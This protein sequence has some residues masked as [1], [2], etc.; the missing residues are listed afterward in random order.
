MLL[1]FLAL[2]PLFCAYASAVSGDSVTF[3]YTSNRQ[4]E[5]EPCDCRTNQIG[6]LN[7]MAEYLRRERKKG[8]S[9]FFD[10]GDSFFSSLPINPL[11]E[12]KEQMRSQLI[13]S[14]YKKM[15]LTAFSPGEKDFALGVPHLNT[16][17]EK[18]GATAVSANLLDMQGLSLF[19][20]YRILEVGKK[21]IGVTG[22][23]DPALVGTLP[24]KVIDWGKALTETISTLRKKGVKTVVVLSHLGL[25]YDRKLAQ[26]FSGVLIF[27]SHSLDPLSQPEN[28]NNSFIFQPLHQGQQLGRL[29]W[30]LA[31]STKVSHRLV[32]LGKNYDVDND[33]RKMMIAFREEARQLALTGESMVAQSHHG[34][35]AN[36]GLCKSCHQ[37][38]YDFWKGTEHASSYL[39]LYAK[40]QHLDSEC[41]GCHALGFQNPAGFKD[42]KD[43]FLIAGD[44]GS[45]FI[46]VFM[47]HI[48]KQDKGSGTL[49]A[50]EQPKR[51]KNLKA[52]YHRELERL[53]LTGTINKIYAGVQ[54]ENCHGNR[55]GHPGIPSSHANLTTKVSVKTCTECHTTER[56]PGFKESMIKQ[57]ACPL[58]KRES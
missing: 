53:E 54:C 21:K 13:A 52:V 8:H 56:S 14:A 25:E 2:F 16:L 4:G 58:M 30:N 10:A 39:P 49:S 43:A 29:D 35:V 34:F 27:G 6:G 38:Q 28:Q 55:A 9:L 31:K 33:V 20:T 46:D 41:I 18:S 15:G 12:K 40:K 51:Y 36:P 5:I 48:F 42:P 3:F 47:A 44:K 1:K 22:V 24:V 37:E 7:R 32:D 11:L 57:V 50:R 17:I 19:S 23:F 26:K 45:G